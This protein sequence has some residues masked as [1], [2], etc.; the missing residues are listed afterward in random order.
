[1]LARYGTSY[2]ATDWMFRPY[3]GQTY[4][5]LRY[6]HETIPSAIDRNLEEV[7][8][9]LSVLENVLSKQQ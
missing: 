1:M 7:M 4:W 5:F 2:Y 6:N 8:R 9:I 3:F